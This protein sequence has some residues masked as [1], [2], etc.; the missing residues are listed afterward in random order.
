MAYPFK[1]P[2]LGYSYDAVEPNIDAKTMEIHHN[3]HHNAYV[4][5]LNKALESHPELHKQELEQLLKNIGGLPQDIQTAVRNN[6]GGHYNHSLFY[7][8]N[9]GRQVWPG[10]DAEAQT[11]DAEAYLRAHASGERPFF[12][13]LSWGPPINELRLTHY[14]QCDF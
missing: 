7:A 12:L 5:N 4:T 2:E 1:L 6:G 8:D 13:M 3:K 11:G 14:I 9:P 10:Y